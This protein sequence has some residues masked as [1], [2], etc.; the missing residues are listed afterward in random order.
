MGATGDPPPSGAAFSHE[1]LTT[2]DQ[3]LPASARP[4]V[5]ERILV[6]MLGLALAAVLAHAARRSTAID[7]PI[8]RRSR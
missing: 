6:A 1:M 5:R 8:S 3:K 7:N 2:G 4:R